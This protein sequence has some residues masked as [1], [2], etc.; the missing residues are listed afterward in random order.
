M[1][2]DL[3]RD[4]LNISEYQSQESEHYQLFGFTSCGPDW[5][6]YIAWKF[7][8]NCHAETIWEGD[9]TDFSRAYELICLVDQVHDFA[10]NQHR[11]FVIK[12]LQPWLELAEDCEM[13]LIREIMALQPNEFP[14]DPDSPRWSKIK[15]ASK[16]ARKTGA[17]KTRLQNRRQVQEKARNRHSQTLQK[18]E[19]IQGS[20][21]TQI[22]LQRTH[23]RRSN[24]PNNLQPKRPRGR[25][26]K[27]ENLTASSGS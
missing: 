2:D 14:Q 9:V 22:Q 26:K 3:A 24:K 6:V 10:A 4:P 1:L 17:A 11:E 25:P 7:L 12:H 8:D 19:T 21:S 18:G 15:Q 5:K 27:C 23:G 13:D 16:Q 20:S